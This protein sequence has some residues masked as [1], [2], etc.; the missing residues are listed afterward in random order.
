MLKEATLRFSTH[1]ISLSI[2]GSIRFDL[3][4]YLRCGTYISNKKNHAN[5]KA[6]IKWYTF[7]KIYEHPTYLNVYITN[8]ETKQH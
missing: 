4:A 5:D 7:N 3:D 2:I 6:I 1:N 8:L